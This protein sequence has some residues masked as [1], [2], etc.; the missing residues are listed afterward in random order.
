MH[1][2]DYAHAE[3]DAQRA[4]VIS[5]LAEL[6]LTEDA[7]AVFIE[8]WNKLDALPTDD[9]HDGRVKQ[10][11]TAAQKRAE[12][13]EGTPKDPLPVG[14]SALTG[15]GVGDLL[16]LLDQELTARRCE[17]S[18][19]LPPDAG[20]AAA[21][22]YRHGDVLSEDWSDGGQRTVKVR[23]EPRDLGRFE[24]TFGISIDQ[25]GID[26]DTERSLAG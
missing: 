8:A 21:W 25:S 23:L 17:I 7:D 15:E 2:R 6:G 9:G 18:V 10:L 3:S 16:E 4:D 11:M 22:L 19:D 5:V 26:E 24:K 14:L 13:A 20:E 12:V 1:V